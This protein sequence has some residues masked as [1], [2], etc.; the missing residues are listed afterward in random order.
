[1]VRWGRREAAG[2]HAPGV[3]RS[4]CR[5]WGGFIYNSSCGLESEASFMTNPNGA[6]NRKAGSRSGCS[7]APACCCLLQAG[8]QVPAQ[9]GSLQCFSMEQRGKRSGAEMLES[10][11]A[12][13]GR[14]DA[15]LTLGWFAKTMRPG[16]VGVLGV[17][18]GTRRQSDPAKCQ[19]NFLQLSHGQP[20]PKHSRC[21]RFLRRSRGKDRRC[22][23]GPLM[24]F[25]FVL[26][27]AKR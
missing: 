21:V 22:D 7:L 5:A 15:A 10:A 1:M 4:G 24:L 12:S 26:H 23:S 11:A 17:A 9:G 6:S 18:R 27:Y 8:A 3:L 25:T 20:F 19:T 14:L 13:F 2:T 16:A